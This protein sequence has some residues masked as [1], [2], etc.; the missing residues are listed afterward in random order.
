MLAYCLRAQIAC[1][2]RKLKIHANRI[3]LGNGCEMVHVGKICRAQEWL[4]NGVCC[5]I[6]QL[7]KCNLTS[8]HARKIA[9][10]VDM[11]KIYFY[12]DARYPSRRRCKVSFATRIQN[13]TPSTDAKNPSSHG[14]KTSPPPRILNQHLATVAKWHISVPTHQRRPTR[15]AR[16]PSLHQCK[17]F[18]PREDAQLLS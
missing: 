8:R 14:G 1:V 5:P 18:P 11:R 7:F 15:C 12:T 3:A 2:K 4:C 17:M 13:I 6:G 10:P 9:R 16:F